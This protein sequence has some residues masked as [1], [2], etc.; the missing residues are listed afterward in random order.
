MRPQDAFK[1]VKYHVE[2]ADF[3]FTING[4]NLWNKSPIKKPDPFARLSV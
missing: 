3:I 1:L 2:A 4:K